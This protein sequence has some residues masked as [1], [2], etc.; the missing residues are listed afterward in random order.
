MNKTTEMHIEVSKDEIKN[1]PTSEKFIVISELQTVKR[2]S[3]LVEEYMTEAGQ[4]ESDETMSITCGDFLKVVEYYQG[5]ICLACFLPSFRE[6]FCSEYTDNTY[7]SH[8]DADETEEDND[9]DE[10]GADTDE[11]GADVDLDNIDKWAC[12]ALQMAND[13]MD[14]I[15]KKKAQAAKGEPVAFTLEEF[16][17]LKNAMLVATLRL[18]TDSDFR[19]SF[20]QRM[21]PQALREIQKEIHKKVQ[22]HGSK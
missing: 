5:N 12:D 1:L 20:R 17:S 7:Q 10:S 16:N 15:N 13:T 19:R 21:M 11:S 18:A 6:I 4:G 14:S 3:D 22:E 2:H 9:T 8:E